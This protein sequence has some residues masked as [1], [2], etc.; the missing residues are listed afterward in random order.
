MHK[1]LCLTVYDFMV[2]NDYKID[3]KFHFITNTLN[4]RTQD[5][6]CPLVYHYVHYCVFPQIILSQLSYCILHE[7]LIVFF[8]INYLLLPFL[9]YST[10]ISE[11]D[12]FTFVLCLNDAFFQT[13]ILLSYSFH[14]VYL[15]LL[16]PVTT[17]PCSFFFF[18]KP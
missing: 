13:L 2:Y 8:L 9:A 11:D 6:T 1:H 4:S 5:F 10:A 3:L 15:T 7:L 17:F 12:I 18:C 16:L 14:R